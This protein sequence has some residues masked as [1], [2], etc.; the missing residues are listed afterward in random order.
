MKKPALQDVVV[1][2][3][4]GVP[5]R[6]RQAPPQAASVPPRGERPQQMP[7]EPPRTMHA[8]LYRKEKR[9]GVRWLVVAVTL[10]VL[11]IL[12]AFFASLFFSG[13]TVTVYPRT[14]TTNVD[15]E[16]VLT[17]EPLPGQLGFE[18]VSF[19]KTASRDV[20]ALSEE[21]VSEFASGQITIRNTYASNAQ[22]LIKRTRFKAPNGAIYRIQESVDVPGFSEGEDGSRVP[23]EVTVVVYAEEAGDAYNIDEPTTFV[24]AAWEGTERG[25]AFV[26]E[27]NGSIA[28]GFSGVR[29]TVDQTT[30]DSV[31][32]ELKKELSDTL[33]A[34]AFAPGAVPDD[35]ILFSD[36]LFFEFVPQSDENTS[37]GTVRI[38]QKAVLHGILF[39]KTSLAEF[40]ASKTLATYDNNPVA[41]S[42][43]TTISVAVSELTEEEE[44][45]LPWTSD[46]LR[47]RISGTAH[48]VWQFDK[49]QLQTDLLDRDK[50]AM[51]TV[52]GGYP[53]IERAEAVLRPFW[54]STFPDNREDIVILSTLDSV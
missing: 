42:D 46:T 39:E 49:E 12:L 2:T 13:A 40:L 21:T 36:A 5:P 9:T 45:V 1:K 51:P 10:G 24:I 44:E 17:T 29:R 41:V 53:G 28:G 16:F 18:R 52:L 31:T 38:R 35:R 32:E 3:P 37:E 7:Q 6:K 23:G 8:P 33:R 20:T 15:A 47:A 43:Y 27:S 48:F 26:V 54:K 30:R 34:E 11:L 22:R 25:D 4:R 14:E 50:T 19:E